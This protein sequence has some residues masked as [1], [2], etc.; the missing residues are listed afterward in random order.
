MTEDR[1]DYYVNHLHV[2]CLTLLR[3]KKVEAYSQDPG[4]MELLGGFLNHSRQLMD[5]IRDREE[6]GKATRGRNP[7]PRR[8]SPSVGVAR[9]TT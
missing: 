3:L 2:T 6:M 9:H 4:F 7:H 5:L 8:L 1:V